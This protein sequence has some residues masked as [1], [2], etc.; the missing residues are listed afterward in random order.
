MKIEVNYYKIGEL[1]EYLAAN[2]THKSCVQSLMKACYRTVGIVHFY[3]LTT[4]SEE[5]Y[6]G[7]M[8][9]NG[10]VMNP[11]KLKCWTLKVGASVVDAAAMVDIHIAR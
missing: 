10:Q 9:S 6:E 7:K 5:E 11:Y 4:L 1:E 2:A 8:D 3:T